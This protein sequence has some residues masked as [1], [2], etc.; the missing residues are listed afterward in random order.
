MEH[1]L[2]KFG[3][4]LGIQ[5]VEQI[6]WQ[7]ILDQV[8]AAIKAMPIRSPKTRK[9]AEIAGH[10]YHV[11]LAWRNEVMHPKVTYTEEEAE[12]LLGQVALFMQSLAAIV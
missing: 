10:L 3:K 7:N 4:K 2:Q 6:V 1:G 5:N 12:N 11:K 8:G 9:Y